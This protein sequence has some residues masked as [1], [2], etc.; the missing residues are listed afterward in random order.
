MNDV[1][2][3][4]GG[5]FKS[6]ETKEFGKKCGGEGPVPTNTPQTIVPTKEVSQCCAMNLTLL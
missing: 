6:E 3:A 5:D 4:S 1:S 2:V